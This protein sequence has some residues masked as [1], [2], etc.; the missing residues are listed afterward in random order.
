MGA[1]GAGLRE[2]K[3]WDIGALAKFERDF[4]YEHPD[5]VA[6]TEDEVAEYRRKHAITLVRGVAPKPVTTFEEAAVPEYLLKEL[7][8]AGFKGPTAIQAQ[9]WPVALSGREMIGLAETGY[10]VHS[11]DSILL[12]LTFHRQTKFWQDPCLLAPRHCP[13]QRTTVLGTRRRSDCFGACSYS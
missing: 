7:Y 6:R 1:L 13:H 3:D 8:A 10:V 9:G 2:I 4:Y 12:P 5:V 11:P